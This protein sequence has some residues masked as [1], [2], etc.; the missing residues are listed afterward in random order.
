MSV[1]FSTQHLHLYKQSIRQREREREKNL[2]L[3]NFTNSGGG[4]PYNI[5][6]QTPYNMN[7][8]HVKVL[9]LKTFFFDGKEKKGRS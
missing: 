2:S 3:L 8:Q 6:S 1:K 5:N 4:E 9:Y 7:L